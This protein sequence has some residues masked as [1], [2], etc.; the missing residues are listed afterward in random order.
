MGVAEV[1]VSLDLVA[2][3]DFVAK[4]KTDNKRDHADL[5]SV[6]EEMMMRKKTTDQWAWA[7]GSL[8]EVEVVWTRKMTDH[9]GS[10][11]LP[12]ER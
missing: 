6:E 2:L 7:W 4:M 1:A 5:D 9:A 3:V 8:I 10:L 12:M 11:T